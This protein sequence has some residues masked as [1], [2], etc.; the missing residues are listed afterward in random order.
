M[1]KESAVLKLEI[2]PNPTEFFM[3]MMTTKEQM[4]ER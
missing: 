1:I 4:K 3:M 2:K